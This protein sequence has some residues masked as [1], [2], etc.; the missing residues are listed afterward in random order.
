MLGFCVAFLVQAMSFRAPMSTTRSTGS[1]QRYM[2]DLSY[3][4]ILEK[5]L[6]ATI[7]ST[8]FGAFPNPPCPR[9]YE[10]LPTSIPNVILL[11]V[12]V[13]AQIPIHVFNTRT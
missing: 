8:L 12:S 7:L 1:S 4:V 9:I 5:R 6:E 11:A 13:P 2:V 3:Y 10:N